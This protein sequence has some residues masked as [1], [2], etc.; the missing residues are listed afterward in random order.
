[1]P[2]PTTTTGQLARP[3]VESWVEVERSSW[4]FS[5]DDPARLAS[6]YWRA[7]RSGAFG[8][9]RP[10]GP[11]LGPIALRAFSVRGPVL[12]RMGAARVVVEEDR[13]HASFP[14]LDGLVV[15]AQGGSL[16]LAAERR[17]GVLRLG[18]RVEDYTPRLHRARR[19]LARLVAI[20]YA[21]AQSSVHDRVTSAYLRTLTE[22]E[23]P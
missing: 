12:I 23:G 1:M 15:G 22:E 10:T 2:P 13:V 4:T 14:I 21:F 5:G 8:L 16:L 9:V 11:P 7:A 6:R 19:V 18:V 17:S 20:P 3:P